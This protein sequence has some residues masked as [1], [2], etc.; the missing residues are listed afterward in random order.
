MGGGQALEQFHLILL[1]LTFS[2]RSLR[3]P[4]KK[5]HALSPFAQKNSPLFRIDFCLEQGR[6]FPSEKRRVQLPR[7]YYRVESFLLISSIAES[8]PPR[9]YLFQRTSPTIIA[10]V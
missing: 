10:R 6:T 8:H 1:W 5:K 4:Q 2:P 7:S 3:S 9:R